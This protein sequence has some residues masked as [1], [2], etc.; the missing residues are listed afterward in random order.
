[1]AWL[2]G[3]AHRRDPVA[4][5]IHNIGRADTVVRDTFGSVAHLLNLDLDIVFVEYPADQ[6][7]GLA[8]AA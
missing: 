6:V 4:K 7:R 5:V 3:P 1:M 8:L 2:V